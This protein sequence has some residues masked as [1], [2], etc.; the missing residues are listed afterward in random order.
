M[1]NKIMLKIS[2]QEAA[3]IEAA[4]RNPHFDCD[5]LCQMAIY[6][7]DAALAGCTEAA[8][9]G[10]YVKFGER[11]FDKYFRDAQE[12]RLAEGNANA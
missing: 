4:L 5:T 12:K 6:C 11:F 3:E 7:L 2:D 8:R 9:Y 1:T 10:L